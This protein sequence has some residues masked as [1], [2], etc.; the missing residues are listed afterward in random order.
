MSQPSVPGGEEG[1]WFQ[2]FFNIVRGKEA[3]QP[4]VKIT[5]NVGE[6][7]PTVT[8][9]GVG[10]NR[11]QAS[12]TSGAGTRLSREGN[13][14]AGGA[15]QV[16]DTILQPG[17]MFKNQAGNYRGAAGGKSGAAL[18]AVSTALSGDP[19]SAV[20]SAPVGIAAGAV[21]NTATT[22]LTQGLM[23]GPA[24][25]RAL[26]M[27]IR[28][29]APSLV[30][31]G[32]QQAVAGAVGGVK[33]RAEK[34][35][36][37]P[38]GG[39]PMYIPGTSIGLN[40]AAL[41]QNQFERDLANRLKEAQTMG[42]YDIDKTK[43]LTDYAINKQIEMLKAQQPLQDHERRQNLIAAQQLQASEG[44]I[45]QSL[46]RQAGLFKL[47]GTAQTEAGQTMRTAIANNPYVGATLS[48]P[49]ISFG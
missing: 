31:G 37:A 32:V 16:T 15:Q 3:E 36:N 34:G 12:V 23:A 39:T 29:L 11:G 27:G 5:G 42:Q 49:S 18:G 28:F 17:G 35:A 22:A 10:I 47:A 46:G 24:P 48:A 43:A 25:A 2:K 21:A 40:Q 33:G 14:I 7:G 19:L 20:I 9:G 8:E 4:G 1:S 38:V 30:G 6:A 41:E 26:G 13:R 44:A 45:Y